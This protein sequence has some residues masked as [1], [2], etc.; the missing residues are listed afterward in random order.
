MGFTVSKTRLAKIRRP[1]II[2]LD[3]PLEDLWAELEAEEGATEKAAAPKKMV[4]AKKDEIHISKTGL[5]DFQ[6]AAKYLGEHCS[7]W[8]VRQ[9]W[10]KRKIHCQRIGRRLL[11]HKTELDRLAKGVS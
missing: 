3:F 1:K 8:S 10:R 5:M 11:V 4:A 9:L 2:K 7:A 6:N